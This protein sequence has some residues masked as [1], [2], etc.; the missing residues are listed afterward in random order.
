MDTDTRSKPLSY[1]FK[2]SYNWIKC[3]IR[4]RKYH[5][6]INIYQF[7]YKKNLI[8]PKYLQR[9]EKGAKINREA[10]RQQLYHLSVMLE[11]N[12]LKFYPNLFKVYLVVQTAMSHPMFIIIMEKI[13]EVKKKKNPYSWEAEISFL[14]SSLCSESSP[15][16]NLSINF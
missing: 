10:T 1:Y 16:S 6:Y 3:L 11:L 15:K 2:Y 14:G 9:S 13:M 5:N 8:Y 12:S 7:S 4:Y